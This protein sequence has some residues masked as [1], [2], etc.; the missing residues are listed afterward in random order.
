M[1]K[2]F[3]SLFLSLFALCSVAQNAREEIKVNPYLGGLSPTPEGYE[4]FYFSHYG[5]HG[6]RYLIGKDV[7]KNPVKVLQAA[8]DAGQ[9]TEKGEDVLK[10]C[11]TI[12]DDAQGRVDELTP[13][14]AQQHRGIA[15]RLSER[16]PEIF[17]K[18]NI[19]DAKSSTIIRCILSMAN[20]MAELQGRNPNLNIKMDASDHDMYYILQEDKELKKQRAPRGSEAEK[21]LNAFR[22]SKF[23]PTRVMNTLFKSEDYW[24]ENVENPDDFIGTALWKIAGLAEMPTGT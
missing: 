8:H 14:G 12:R 22:K 21:A 24:K 16:F 10:K 2:T 18:D 5:R 4:V 9:L 20:E 13:L 11:I 17:G 19:I 3:F 15:R 1:K 23:D 6:S 7:Y